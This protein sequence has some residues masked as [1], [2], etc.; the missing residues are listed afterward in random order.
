[1]LDP[2]EAC[3]VRVRTADGAVVGGGLL[4]TERHVIS[5]AHVV[6]VAAGQRLGAVDPP[7]DPVHLDLARLPAAGSLQARVVC[8]VPPGPDGGDIAVLELTTPAPVAARPAPLVADDDLWHHRFRV[9]GFPAG[10]DNGIYATGVLLGRQRTGWLQLEGTAT[11]GARVERG[12]SGAPVWDENLDCVA[13][14]IVATVTPAQAKAGFLIPVD[15]LA[16]AWPPLADHRRPAARL[17]SAQQDRI[18][19]HVTAMRSDDRYAQWVMPGPDGPVWRAVPP[20]ATRYRSPA[21]A[22]QPFLERLAAPTGSPPRIVLLGAPGGGKTTTLELLVH[23]LLTDRPGPLPIVVELRDYAGEASLLPLIRD[24]LRQHGVLRPADDEVTD[25]L[26]R[27][28]CIVL[29]DGL[30]EVTADDRASAGV[31]VRRLT[32]GHPRTGVVVTCRATD[33]ADFDRDLTG[34]EVLE[35]APWQPDQ[36]ARFLAVNGNGGA[37]VA[38]LARFDRFDDP[39]ILSNPL[40]LS[41]AAR[42]EPAVN[43]DT[44]RVDVLRGYL[45]GDRVAGRV[46]TRDGLRGKLLPTARR[47]AYS[48]LRRRER[49]LTVDAIFADIEDERGPRGYRA[50]DMFTALHHSGLLV[51]DAEHGWFRHEYLQEFLAAEQFARQLT[52]AQVVDLAGDGSWRQMVTLYLSMTDLAADEL[53]RFLDP[54]VDRWVRYHAAA[55]RGGLDTAMVTVPGGRV[56]LGRDDGPDTEKPA[57]DAVLAAFEIDPH[58]VTNAQYA[59]FLADTGRRSPSSWRGGRFPPAVAAHPVTDIGW[60]DARDY[61]AWAGKRLPTEAE[62]ETAATWFHD[63]RKTRWPWGDTFHPE[64]LNSDTSVRSW[65]GGPTPVGMYPHGASRYGAFDLSGNVWEWTSSLLRPYPYDPCDGREDPADP[66]LRVLR[67]GSWRSTSPEFVSGT[68]RDAFALDPRLGGNVGF[69]CARDAA[70]RGEPT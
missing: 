45:T 70:K 7:T 40:L 39:T 51:S 33:F 57:H 65:V 32:R 20:R 30:S 12:F 9:L 59:H 14:M 23:R 8:W 55:G 41:L 3:V 56:V 69:R 58:P 64:R 52:P 38:A 49:R 24:A 35:L 18:A 27:H 2:L 53:A 21:A 63:G 5:C 26:D 46:P 1:M 61:A 48:G 66:G 34:F 44:R 67:G 31:A 43:P 42:L 25:L 60:R 16:N 22:P 13:G 17:P 36:I 11:T 29:C 47:L 15:L 62:W 50:E 6:A 28:D 54:R 4:A 10:H 37:T 19:R 68:K